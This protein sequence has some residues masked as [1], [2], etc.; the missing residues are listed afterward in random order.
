VGGQFQPERIAFLRGPELLA[1]HQIVARGDELGGGVRVM[2]EHQTAN[3]ADL[4]PV[5]QRTESPKSTDNPEAV[6]T[7]LEHDGVV[8]GKIN[9][10]VVDDHILHIERRIDLVP[11]A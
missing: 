1:V 5:V 8:A 2:A 11:H 4:G 6:I 3:R 9:C 10:A 7:R